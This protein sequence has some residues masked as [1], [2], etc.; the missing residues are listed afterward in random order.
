[1]RINE[2]QLRRIVRAQ[3]RLILEAEEAPDV[4]KSIKGSAASEK[5]SKLLDNAPQ[6]L[7]NALDKIDTG[8]GLAAFLQAVLARV[9]EKN[10]DQGEI[11]GA[12]KKVVSAVNSG[13]D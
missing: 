5:A 6:A 12:L 3:V 11:N 9:A 2:S 1:M 13:S 7:K 10:I 8:T 4:G